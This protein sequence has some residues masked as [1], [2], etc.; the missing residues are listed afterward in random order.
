MLGKLYILQAQPAVILSLDLDTGDVQTVLD[1]IYGVPDGIQ[2][3]AASEAIF[4]TSMGKP[5]ASGEEFL[6]DDGT[7]ERCGIGGSGHTTLIGNGA[8]VTPKQLQLHRPT[9]TLYWCDREGMALMSSRTDGGN[10][11]TI[12]RTGE[13]PDQASEILR[14]CVGIALD[15]QNG[16]IYWTQKGPAD[17]N[18]RRIFRV[19]VDFESGVMSSGNDGVELLLDG[20]PEPID[21][22]IDLDRGKL[23]WTDRG[24]PSAQGNSLNCANVS[25]TGLSD[26][27][28]LAT[29]LQEGIGLALDDAGQRIF[30]SDL[31]GTIR[32]FSMADETFAVVHRFG[33]PLTGIAFSK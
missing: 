25:A 15:D 13:W 4:W 31:G 30:V 24:D 20:L 2:I 22:E 8:I 14:H 28:V 1:G 23:Y 17:G 32:M 7:V 19:S 29:G 11:R 18:R 10:L 12:L 6:A 21:L 26:H 16:Y 3:D 27:V 5:P 33:K 9:N